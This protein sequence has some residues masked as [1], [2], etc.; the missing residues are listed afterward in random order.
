MINLKK[1][2]SFV[3]ELNNQEKANEAKNWI[4]DAIKRPGALRKKMNKAK[5]EKI[6]IG[7]IDSELAVLRKRDK[8]KKI[9]GLQLNKSDRRKHKQ[10]VLAKTL[11]KF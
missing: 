11:R 5:G 4:K 1:F 2:E 3:S 6:S 7:E 8:N 9:P 10:L